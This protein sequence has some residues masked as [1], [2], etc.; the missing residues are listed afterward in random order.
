MKYSYVKVKI[1]FPVIIFAHVTWNKV[2]IP[3]NLVNADFSI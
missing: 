2:M 1:G 3:R